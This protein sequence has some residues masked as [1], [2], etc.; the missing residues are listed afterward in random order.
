MCISSTLVL[1]GY[2]MTSANN[3]VCRPNGLPLLCSPGSCRASIQAFPE[4][5]LSLL[6]GE[7]SPSCLAVFSLCNQEGKSACPYSLGLVCPG[8]VLQPNLNTILLK[9]FPAYQ[10]IW[11]LGDIGIR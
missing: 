7:G 8:S 10:P 3:T 9:L 6:S 1:Y 2:P 4:G 5:F 11:L